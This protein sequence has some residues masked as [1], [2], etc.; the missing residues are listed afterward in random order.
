MGR[1][2]G[3]KGGGETPPAAKQKQRT[4]RTASPPTL[5]CAS[6]I[7]DLNRIRMKLRIPLMD[8]MPQM[9]SFLRIWLVK[10]RCSCSA[11]FPLSQLFFCRKCAQL[12]C[13]I[14][15][16]EEIDFV[17][18]PNCM[19]KSTAVDIAH[20]T[21]RCA[22]C[23]EC[24]LCKNV[25]SGRSQADVYYLQCNSCQWTSRTSEGAERSM[26]KESWTE[27]TN[28]ME[29]ELGKVMAIMKRLSNFERFERE[30]NRRSG[31]SKLDKFGTFER[32]TP[33]KRMSGRGILRNDRFSL[34]N[35]YNSRRKALQKQDDV[36]E[37]L[38]LLAPSADVP[39]L[40]PDIF[41]VPPKFALSIEQTIAHPLCVSAAHLQPTKVK[42]MTRR[43]FRCSECA[44][45][46]YRGQLSPNDVKPRLQSFALDHFPEIRI[47]RPVK[48]AP[49]QN[50]AIFLTL[51][52]NSSGPID[53]SLTGK[54]PEEEE[55]CVNNSDFSLQIVLS[56]RDSTDEQPKM[57]HQRS[58][59]RI[60]SISQHRVGIC[61]ECVPSADSIDH[62]ALF[63]L[64][65][66]HT[67][68]DLPEKKL[69]SDVKVSLKQS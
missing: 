23:N 62:Y 33:T 13:P 63:S 10:Y 24:P 64:S 56:N 69:K 37:V 61:A 12:K 30:M 35:A 7:R 66:S 59:S 27:P 18:C 57:A 65:F 20:K 51:T 15:I 16:N 41:S 3:G 48:L 5:L 1:K 45:M 11:W 47:S 52:N 68:S 32:E 17:F 49:G 60:I 53:I 8:A 43:A 26:A 31:M 44:T 36:D 29:G 25:L 21:S 2:K 6:T 22:K 58:D 4:G 46:L 50:S 34:Q 14:C 54:R 9:S 42:M 67:S 28:P 39:E 40:D 55:N 19:E 38:E